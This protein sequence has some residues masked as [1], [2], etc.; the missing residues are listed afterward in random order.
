[1]IAKGSGSVTSFSQ[2]DGFI[3][4]GA[5][6]ESVAN[7]TPVAVQRIGRARRLADLVIMGSHCVGLDM[8]IERLA[9]EGLLVKALNIGSTG[10]LAAAKRGECDVAPIHLMHPTSG[11]YNRPFLTA[12]LELLPGY[13][14][15][16]GMV[17]R[18]GDRR[19]ERPSL[20]TAL[21]AA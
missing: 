4:I 2:A 5:Q 1:P 6:I 11:E 3:A 21:A 16:Q 15:L 13:R 17:F 12:D 8:I 18:R 9:G 20:E 10:G 7:D 14:R 19:F